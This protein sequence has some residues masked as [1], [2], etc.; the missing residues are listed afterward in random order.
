MSY[1]TLMTHV[2]IDRGCAARLRM[3]LSVARALSV[4]AIGVGAQAPWPFDSEGDGRGADYE[5]LV[6]SARADI[7]AAEGVFRDACSKAGV[8]A[9]WRS[10]VAYPNAVL[11]RQARLAD[12]ILAYRRVSDDASA[13]VMPDNLLMEAGIPVLFM[14]SRE[15]E[16]KAET[17][18]LAWK[19]TR[20]A[21]RALALSLPLLEKTKRVLVAAICR[22]RELETVERELG[23]IAQR[24]Q[25][26]GINAATL[27]EVGSPGAA[28]S[29]L[30]RI[31]QADHS[32]LI[33]AGGFGHSR[34]REWVLGGVTD[35]LI[36]DGRHYVLL[37]H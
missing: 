18:L 15:R 37:S 23:D 16:F 34:M 28:G 19:N 3:T 13:Y 35:D 5:L 8:A 11:T 31:A 22:D 21:R 36:S 33:V 6:R 17:V 26:R 29:K 27:A 32:D 14:P 2:T 9:D 20:E 30:L 7:A 10:E 25:G 1:R 24:L 12:V 4:Q